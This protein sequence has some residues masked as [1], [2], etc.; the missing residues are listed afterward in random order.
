MMVRNKFSERVAVI[1]STTGRSRTQ[2][3]FQSMCDI[4]NIVG[5]INK[6]VSIDHIRKTEAR[7][8]DF[9][10]LG[11]YAVNLDKVAKAQ[12]AFEQLP[13]DLRNKFKNSIPGFFEFV[14]DEKNFDECVQLGLF[15]A[16]KDSPVAEQP[17]VKPAEPAPGSTKSGKMKKPPVV[18][19]K[20][21]DGGEEA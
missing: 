20:A 5:Q 19:P 7:F 8:G 17:G 6:G 2:T 12:Q 21:T 15:E 18:E 14:R 1:A 16:K 11:E 13:S 3:Q 9:R 10:E 4:R